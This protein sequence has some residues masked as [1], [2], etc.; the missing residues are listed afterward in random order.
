MLSAYACFRVKIT[1]VT[2]Y[3][4][5]GI[6]ALP[7]GINQTNSKVVITSADQLSKIS[8][9]LAQIKAIETIVVFADSKRT[10]ASVNKFREE[11]KVSSRPD[12]QVYTLDELEKLGEAEDEKP[13]FDEP[14]ADDLA[15]IMYTSGSTGNPKGVMITHGNVLNAY[16]GLRS[17]LG[18]QTDSEIYLSYLPLAH[19]LEM[20][21]QS[22]HLLDGNAIG[23]S[24]AQ[25]MVDSS[26]AI[27]AGQLGDVKVLRPT[28]LPAVPIV[29]E[30][31]VKAV[32]DQVAKGSW[33]KQELFRIA[34]AQ[35]LAKFK[36]GSSTYLLDRIVFNKINEAV[37]GG[38]VKV[39]FS[40][41]AILSTEVNDFLRVCFCPTLQAYGLTET[42][43][44]G[45][46]QFSTQ[47]EAET[48]GSVL[49]CSQI[50][51]RDW[52]EAGYR[53]TDHPNPRGEI[54]VCGG[55][56]TLGYYNMPEKTAEDY[57]IA[58]DNSGNGLKCFATGDIGEMMPNGNLKII[59]RKKDLVK[60]S[61]GEYVSLNKIESLV[62]LS[63]KVDNVCVVALNSS[64]SYCVALVCPNLKHLKDFVIE[65][66]NASQNSKIDFNEK[67]SD[68]LLASLCE[69][70]D[71]SEEL[72]N[73]LTKELFDLCV[74]Q[75]VAKFEIPLR[76]KF[77]KEIWLPDTGLV[78][79]SLKLKRKALQEFYASDIEK[80]Y[81]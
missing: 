15:A 56:V 42:C 21:I 61:G 62:K 54:V 8:Q 65:N 35:K 57:W 3:A 68:I 20:S 70:F 31:I 23:Y 32:K 44:A 49:P 9:V 66:A 17:R 81:S 76:M 80:L 16:L 48:T 4:T 71:K 63:P 33:L 67:N 77:V 60:L 40:G 55:N 11:I 53:T 46:G 39:I 36:R 2:L 75:G 6:D 79:D 38:R 27:K 69:L 22:L 1:V 12:L 78:T 51:L 5:L 7:F 30:R 50:R 18:K 13:S 19:I 47:C 14:K 26:T 10:L 74:S 73:K 64:K 58:K 24:S 28:M 52:T 59:D 37:L 25:T 41:G 43:A 72:T 45:V 34:F 29:L